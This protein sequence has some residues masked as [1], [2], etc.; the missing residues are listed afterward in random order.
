MTMKELFAMGI[1]MGNDISAQFPTA[2]VLEFEKVYKNFC[3][4]SKK[5][6]VG[7]KY[8]KFEDKGIIESKGFAIVRRDFCLWQRNV[9][10]ASVDKLILDGSTI[11]TLQTLSAFMR[12]ILNHQVPFE[13]LVLSK[14]LNASYK[15]PNHIHLQVSI[16]A[17]RRNPGRGP[18]SGDRVQ[19]VVLPPSLRKSK[20]MN[21]LYNRGE[22]AA[23]AKKEKISL[24]LE[25]Y[26]RALVNPLTKL[27]SVFPTSTQEKVTS[28]LNQAL[29]EAQRQNN[30]LT[31]DLMTM[32]QRGPRIK[33]RLSATAPIFKPN[34]DRNYNKRL[35]PACDVATMFLRRS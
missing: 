25:H 27:F 21:K 34:K 30:H 1:Q 29:S 23:Y 16:K 12:T 8:E 17:E 28:V 22:D 18:K 26:I 24:D 33:K 9:L 6:Y 5:C 4:M 7:L 35:K 19:F 3:M 2:I 14:K 15:K 10:A 13:E 32:F 11:L 20:E 31:C